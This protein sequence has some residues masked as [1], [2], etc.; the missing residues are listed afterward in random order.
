MR[1][2]AALPPPPPAPSPSHFAA[3]HAPATNFVRSECVCVVRARAEFN[4]QGVRREGVRRRKLGSGLF[5]ISFFVSVGLQE[6]SLTTSPT[7]TTTNQLNQLIELPSVR[8]VRDSPL[9]SVSPFFGFY[10]FSLLFSAPSA[11]AALAISAS[12]AR[13]PSEG[14]L[15]KDSAKALR[16]TA[17]FVRCRAVLPP[18]G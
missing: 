3:R 10:C 15:R 2:S 1:R 16:L 4:L 17:R 9:V 13:W 14:S 18:N 5:L 7:T 11:L 8:P 12:C 6:S